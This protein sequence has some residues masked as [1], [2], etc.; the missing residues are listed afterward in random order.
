MEARPGRLHL[1]APRRTVQRVPERLQSE[2]PRLLPRGG[3]KGVPSACERP[4]PRR[5]LHRQRAR[6]VGTSGEGR[7]ARD[8]ARRHDARRRRGRPAARALGASGAGG[9]SRGAR[10]LRRHPRAGEGRLPCRDR[11]PLL[12]R[13]DGGDP[14]RRSEPPC[15]GL[16]LRGPLRGASRGV[17]SRREALR[18]RDREHLSHRPLRT[19]RRGHGPPRGRRQGL[20]HVRRADGAAG[21]G[22]KARRRDG[23]ELPREGFGVAVH[24][25]RRAAALHTGRARER[26]RSCGRTCRI[27]ARPAMRARTATTD[28]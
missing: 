12:F 17:G 28:S 10:H 13:H 2:V 8:R 5:L 15:D 16:P 3:G 14:R 1:P 7:K 4:R 25:G 19:E 22:G 11:R 24:E 21:A 9:V 27:R 18:R 6:V 26:R 20:R 23:V